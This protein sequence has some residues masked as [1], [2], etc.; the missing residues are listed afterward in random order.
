M[1]RPCPLKT[2]APSPVQIIPSDEYAM[3]FVPC[4]NAN[5]LDN[6]VLYEMPNAAPIAPPKIDSPRPVQLIPSYEY[7]M[8]FVPSPTLTNF[9]SRVVSA[10]T[11]Y[12]L[13]NVD[14]PIPVQVMP[15]VE[16]AMPFVPLPPATHRDKAALYATPRP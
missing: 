16:Y 14:V 2:D 8:R 7:A 5:H 1:P 10:A 12:A 3:V 6:S 9:A 13:V 4:P 15:S 11:L